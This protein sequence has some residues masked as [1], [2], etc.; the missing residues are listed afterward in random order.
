MSLKYDITQRALGNQQHPNATTR[1][2]R[3]GCKRFA[4]WC[5]DNGL[6]KI[7][8]IEKK[9]AV[10]VIQSY[11]DY[12][13]VSG[14]SASTIHTYIFPVCRAFRVGMSEI[15]KPA[16]T[17]TTITRSRDPDKNTRGK[18]EMENPK[19]QR[20]V[21]FQKVVGIR[22]AELARPGIAGWS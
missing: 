11:A 16:R 6:N 9:G 4:K 3:T 15:K 22:R 10:D 21:E 8:K 17:C 2:I 20:L 14:Y 19:Y 7:A 13:T 12:L 5:V 1:A 18:R